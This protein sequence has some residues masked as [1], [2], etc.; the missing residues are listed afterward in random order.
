MID[1]AAGLALSGKKVFCYA[2]A[3]F[4]TARCY[5]QIKCALA[6]MRLPVTLI[7]VGV[8][9][10]YDD[11]GPTHYTTEDLACLRALPGVE[12]LSPA[13]AESAAALDQLALAHPAPAYPPSRAT[14]AAAVHDGRFAASINAGL[15]EV[16]TGEG[17]C[18]VAQGYMLH[19][20]L[21][22]RELLVRTT[23]DH[24]GVIDL[25]RVKPLEADVLAARARPLLERRDGR[26]A[27]PARR[28]RLG[29]AGG[30]R[31]R[32]ALLPVRRSVSR[33]ASSSRTAAASTCSPG[34]P[35]V[36][37]VAAAVRAMAARR[38]R[39]DLTDALATRPRHFAVLLARPELRADLLTRFPEAAFNGRPAAARGRRARA[40]PADADAASWDSNASTTRCWR[41]SRT[42]ADRQVRRRARQ[43]RPRAPAPPAGSRSAG[44]RE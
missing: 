36:D 41:A 25:F 9:L 1:L 29:R 3:S 37:H 2:M 7:A 28:V 19:R 21:A 27:V 35:D 11:A 10:G 31:R 34:G 26:G 6:A 39:G 22:A 42:S 44:R 8:G 12:V 38:G 13:D 30:A 23:G 33:T 32:G 4:I 18:L 14:G 15:A 24:P 20:A 16:I 5:E 40:L 43:H 17:V